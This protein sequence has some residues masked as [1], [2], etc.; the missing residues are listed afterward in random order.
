MDSNLKQKFNKNC[1]Y[2]CKKCGEIPLLDFSDFD[3]DIICR[4]HKILNVPISKF[5]DFI[6][7]DYECSLCNKT[8]NKN[9]LIYCFKCKLFYCD[10]CKNKHINEKNTSHFSIGGTEKNTICEKHNKKYDKFCFKCKINL[11]ELCTNHKNHYIELIKDN[12][13]LNEDIFKFNKIALEIFNKIEKKEKEEKEINEIQKKKEEEE[14]IKEKKNIKKQNNNQEK[15]SL[16]ND[17]ENDN[18]SENSDSYNSFD[19]NHKEDHEK[20][21]D[22]LNK[23]KKVLKIKQLLIENFYNNLLDISNYYYINNINNIIRCTIIKTINTNYQEF[24]IKY[25]DN[26]EA[27]DDLNN[28]KNKIS[29]KSN[30]EGRYLAVWCMKKLNDIQIKSGQILKLIAFGT[31][32]Y[33]IILL[34]TMNF[35]FYQIIEEHNG[36]VYSLDQYKNDTKYF[37]SSS[38]DGTINIYKLDNNYKYIL[39]QKLKK[40][41]EKYGNE[42]NKV[43]IL[44]NK[45]LISSDRRSITIWKSYSDE[46][47]KIHYE[48]FYEI[49]VNNDTCQLLEVNPSIFIATQYST[50][51]FQVYKN[52]GKTFPLIG[53]LENIGTHGNSSNGLCKI[54]DKLVCSGSKDQFYVICIDPIQVIQKYI[55]NNDTIYYIYSTNENYIYCSYGEYG[56]IQYKILFDE[57]NNFIE[58]FEIDKYNIKDNS[59]NEEAILPFDDGRIFILANKNQSKYYQLIA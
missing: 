17:N 16:E 2:H 23:Q 49:I 9:N 52:D 55:I 28:I 13:P 37:F 4:K 58:L 20:N 19:F 8:F 27:K 6:S 50:R 14:N 26:I 5:Y 32:R 44:S 43:I 48:D 39:F 35:K 51:L 45:L 11:C 21:L 59:L 1:I 22:F 56:I 42:I 18:E 7:F 38:K 31:S 24:D 33:E 25:I 15:E 3:L 10:I 12:Y 34:N 54:N 30:I 41:E 57:D 53:E 40:S 46:K 29:I 47:D 36:T